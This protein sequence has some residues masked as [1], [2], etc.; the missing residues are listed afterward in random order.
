MKI[1]RK[2]L[3]LTAMAASIAIGG[4]GSARADAFAQSI[5]VI[6]N[7]RLLNSSGTPFNVS[8]FAMLT[9]TNDAHATGSLNGTF[10]N[11]AQSFGILSGINPDVAQQTVGLPNPPLAEN[12]FS[13]FP[14]P[15]GVPGTFGY[16]DQNLSGS[17]ITVGDVPAGALAQTR[18]DASLA[19]NGMASGNSDVGTSTTFSFVMGAEDTMTIAFEAN[20]YTQAHVSADGAPTTNANAR[21]SWSINIVD[22]TT[23]LSVFS[24]APDELNG[25]SNV[26]RTDGFPGTTTYDP[27][28]LNFSATTG[29]LSVDSTYQITIQHNTLANALQNQ[30]VPE[31]ATLAIFGLGVLG[32]GT[33]GRRR[34]ST[35]PK[36]FDSNQRLPR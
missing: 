12:D 27:G 17:A 26:S 4:M 35:D 25:A 7:F 22:M 18:A 2:T 36:H 29:M 24:F 33:I 9:G 10:A 34:F 14:A 31:P 30:A 11:G 20:P 16:A 8:D 19:M 32:L 15:P 1:V 21:L 3:L 28:T 23:G 5:L 13:P 6:N